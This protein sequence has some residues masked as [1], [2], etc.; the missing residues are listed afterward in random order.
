MSR[1]FPGPKVKMK[2]SNNYF[3]SILA[4]SALKHEKPFEKII[5]IS[6]AGDREI[7]RQYG[8]SYVLFK[9]EE[10]VDGRVAVSVK[11][12]SQK[13][14]SIS[15]TRIWDLKSPKSSKKNIEKE[16]S[17]SVNEVCQDFIEKVNGIGK[18]RI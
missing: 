6:M 15:K 14:E 9:V 3:P 16:I 13:S 10:Y 4:E 1:F 17:K 18:Y 7:T 11:V 5:S 8:V 2:L 12:K